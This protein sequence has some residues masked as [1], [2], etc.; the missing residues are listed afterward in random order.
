[1]QLPVANAC[2]RDDG[3][4]EGLHLAGSAFQD[5]GFDTVFVADMGVQ[6][7]DRKIV[8]IVLHARQTGGQLSLVVVEDV[9]QDGHAFGRG[10]ALQIS[11]AEFPAQQIPNGLRAVG[12]AAALHELV[13]RCRKIVVE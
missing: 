8:V 10:T 3:L 12:I 6:G 13:E 11:L 2:F 9:T 1:M 5:R 7:G 4:A